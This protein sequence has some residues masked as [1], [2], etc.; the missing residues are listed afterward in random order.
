MG[1]E[2]RKVD[3]RFLLSPQTPP[4]S[5]KMYKNKYTELIGR[6]DPAAVASESLEGA[7]RSIVGFL[8]RWREDAQLD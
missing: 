2:R 7:R 5:Q 6:D 8:R 1:N 4:P 3:G